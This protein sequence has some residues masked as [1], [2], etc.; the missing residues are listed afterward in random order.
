M[1]LPTTQNLGQQSQEQP[2]QKTQPL[3]RFKGYADA[4][5]GEKNKY[6]CFK[7]HDIDHS[8]NLMIR[9]VEKG[10]K[11]RAAFHEFPDKRTVRIEKHAQ[12]A[13]LI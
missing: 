5:D 13:G 6:L 4:P 9:F 12:Q 7:T 10:W 2:E 1:P 8:I 11:F 3:E